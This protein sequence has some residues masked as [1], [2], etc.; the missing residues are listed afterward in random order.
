MPFGGLEKA[1]RPWIKLTDGI[2]GQPGSVQCGCCRFFA[3]ILSLNTRFDGF[4][5]PEGNPAKKKAF[6][7]FVAMRDDVTTAPSLR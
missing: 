4:F 3:Q 6:G 1:L 7:R 5:E 2:E